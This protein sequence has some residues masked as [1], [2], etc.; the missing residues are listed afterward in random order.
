LYLH[1]K[2]T[3]FTGTHLG[4]FSILDLNRQKFTNFSPNAINGIQFAPDIVNVIIPS[5]K[6]YLLGTHNGVVEFDPVDLKFTPY[7]NEKIQS[8]IGMIIFSLLE[9]SKGKLWIGTEKNGLFSYNK[10]TLELKHYKASGFDTTAIGSNTIHQIFEDHKFRLWI[11]TLGGGLSQYFQEKDA[12]QTYNS[13]KKQLPSNFIY[14]IQESRYGNLWIASSRGL[15]R[16]DVEN[17]QFYNYVHE[18]GFPLSE[19]NEGAL[20]LTRD[21]EIFIGGINGLISFREADI[22]KKPA[23]TNL[24]FTAL[25]VNNQIVVPGDNSDILTQDIAF[26]NSIKL[27]PDQTVFSIS[28]ASCNYI[29]TYKNRYQYKL[30]NFDKGWVPVN[31]ESTIL[32][33]NLNPGKYQLKIRVLDGVVDDILAEKSLAIVIVPPFYKTWLAYFVYLLLFVT[34]VWWLNQIYL[35]RTRLVDRI[36]SEQKEKEQIQKFQ[37]K[38]TRN[39]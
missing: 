26:T 32:Y 5:G 16:F 18:K 21:G 39:Y 24:I 34:I 12:F 8:R 22:L 38:F 15:T 37:Q 13:E 11:A 6:K 14:G 10:E 23:P 7:F 27:G 31:N 17:N 36:N 9:D 3:L 4:G 30:E 25:S 29:S 28:F 2:S 33:T 20:L 1:N 19:L 35:S